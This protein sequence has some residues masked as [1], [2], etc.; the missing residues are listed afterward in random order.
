MRKNR[1]PDFEEYAAARQRRLYRMA[2]LLCGDLDRAQDLTQTT[3]VKLLQHWRSA[4]RADNLDAYARTVLTHAYLA[5]ERRALIGR[6]AHSFGANPSGPG[7]TDLRVTLLAA[8]GELPPK[9]RAMVVLRYWEDL[10]VETVAT[11]MNCSTGTV[12]S[13]CSRS[14]A[15]LRTHLTEADLHA[16]H[17]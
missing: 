6:R 8:L 4:S 17:H 10:S 11:L 9:A 13:Q 16:L 5:E 14:L 15:R 7:D 1:Y 12:K 2:Y 3:L